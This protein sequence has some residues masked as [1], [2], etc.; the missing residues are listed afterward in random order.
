MSEEIEGKPKK[1]PFN[2]ALNVLERLGT[3]LREITIISSCSQTPRAEV[4]SVK[5]N[6]VKE[7]FVQASPLLPPK[8]VID[9]GSIIALEMQTQDRYGNTMGG[10]KRIGKMLVYN[11]QLDIKLSMI[12]I[13]IQSTLKEEGYIMPLAEEEELY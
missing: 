13:K 9:H 8:F 4:Q 5:L 6:M 10:R 11:P 3:T 2:M 1:A 7:F 12:L